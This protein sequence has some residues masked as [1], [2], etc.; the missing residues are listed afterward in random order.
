MT[1]ESQPGSTDPFDY[2]PVSSTPGKNRFTSL[3]ESAKKPLAVSTIPLAKPG[4]FKVTLKLDLKVKLQ[5]KQ[6]KKKK[7]A[8]K[9]PQAVARIAVKLVAAA[10]TGKA[11]TSITVPVEVRK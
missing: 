11:T 10:P 3:L 9:T 2:E 1:D 8:K 7:G 4:S 6:G 5:Y